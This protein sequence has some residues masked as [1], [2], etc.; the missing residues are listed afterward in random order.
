MEQRRRDKSVDKSE[1]KR[2]RS[3]DKKDEPA[4]KKKP[5]TLTTKTGGAYIPP[6]RLR[7]RIKNLNITKKY[8]NINK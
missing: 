3:A 5:E 2:E 8:T 4:A 7:Y 1:R 6:A